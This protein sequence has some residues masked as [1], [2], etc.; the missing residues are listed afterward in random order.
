MTQEDPAVTLETPT[1]PQEP[2]Q[3]PP[4]G[5]PAE[6]APEPPVEGQGEPQEGQITN[7]EGL[8][9]SEWFPAVLEERD[10]VRDEGRKP[11][12]QK[13]MKREAYKDFDPHQQR[14]EASYANTLQTAQ[15]IARALRR[16][17]EDGNLTAAE[18][19]RW[20][21]DNAEAW[22]ALNGSHWG[23]GASHVFQQLAAASGDSN[24]MPAMSVRLGRLLFGEADGQGNVRPIQDATFLT[25]FFAKLVEAKTE[26]M[27]SKQEAEEMVTKAKEAAIKEYKTANAAVQQ[28]KP[29]EPVGAFAPGSP[30]GSKSDEE[31]LKDPTTSVQEL[32]A[33]RARQR[34]GQ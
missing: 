22:N 4:I 17:V 29:G 8:E 18:M 10:R 32:I 6:P 34:A 26:G 9:K 3:P 28:A 20:A 21:E 23:K 2:P 11:G 5:A 24:I 31:R 16:Q 7:W 13:E 33:I 27:V 30:A 25:D 14:A 15:N 12:L 19:N 1:L